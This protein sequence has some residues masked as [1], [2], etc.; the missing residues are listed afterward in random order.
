MLLLSREH[1]DTAPWLQ[2]LLCESHDS[3]C[4]DSFAFH[5]VGMR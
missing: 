1:G 2:R 4:R 3:Q 5:K